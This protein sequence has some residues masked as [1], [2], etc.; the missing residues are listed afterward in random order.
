[1]D[2]TF[3]YPHELLQLLI[4]TPPKL[5]KSK[6]DLLLFFQGAGVSASLI[7][8][9]EKLLE[10]DKNR[11]N[12]YHVTRELLTELNKQGERA[13]FVGREIVK[14][15]TEFEDLVFVGKV[16]APPPAAYPKAKNAAA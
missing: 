14:R 13:L 11:F 15:V 12:K 7:C 5:S 8:S 6:R 4:D 2:I 16:T 1:V 10:V 9:Y 3:H